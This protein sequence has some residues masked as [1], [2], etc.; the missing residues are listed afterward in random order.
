MSLTPDESTVLPDNVGDLHTN[1]I[2]DPLKYPIRGHRFVVK[3]EKFLA[4]TAFKSIDGFTSEISPLEYREGTWATLGMRRVPGMLGSYP[5]ITL[6]KGMYNNLDLYNY[7]MG[8]LQGKSNDVSDVTITLY[9]NDATPAASWVAYNVWPTRYEAA[10]LNA[11]SSE[12]IIETLSLA[13]E[14]VYRKT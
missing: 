8:Y 10:G 9:H 1:T 12:I 3:F 5:D 4:T 11:D 7:F 14:G 2:S 6:T 13:T